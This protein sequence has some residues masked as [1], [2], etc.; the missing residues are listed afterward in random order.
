[1]QLLDKGHEQ[2]LRRSFRNPGV[3]ELPQCVVN[4]L[5]GILTMGNGLSD[6]LSIKNSEHTRDPFANL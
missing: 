3:S 2:L 4:A 6:M 5:Q 1:M